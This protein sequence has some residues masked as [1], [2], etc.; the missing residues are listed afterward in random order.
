MHKRLELDDD[1]DEKVKEEERR[2][3]DSEGKKVS[4]LGIKEEKAGKSLSFSYKNQSE[5]PVIIEDTLDDRDVTLLPSYS[6]SLVFYLKLSD[7]ER[8]SL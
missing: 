4:G 3:S 1:D 2:L 7:K 6:S 5:A 8:Q